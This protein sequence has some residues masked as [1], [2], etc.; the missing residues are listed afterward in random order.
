MHRIYKGIVKGGVI[1]LEGNGHLPDGTEVTVI[2]E[3][4]SAAT[5]TVWD[6]LAEIA[7][8]FSS[9]LTDVSERKDEHVAE[10]IERHHRPDKVREEGA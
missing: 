5:K 8:M 4:K 3:E 7:G 9:G 6:A 2:V 1:V 10:A